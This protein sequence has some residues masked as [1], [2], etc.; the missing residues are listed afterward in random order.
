MP[1]V[2]VV[3]DTA[4]ERRRASGLL[5]RKPETGD[6]SA[7]TVLS[8]SNGE[9]ALEIVKKTRP[10]VIVT[11]LMMPGMNGLELVKQVR[12]HHPSIPVVLMTAHGSE[13]IASLALKFGA[14]G[15]VP[16]K[17]LARDLR[18]TIELILEMLKSDREQRDVL[19]H[20]EGRET[21][22]SLPPDP[23]LVD[24]AVNYFRQQLRLMAIFDYIDELRVTIALREALVNAFVHGCLEISS[25]LRTED[26]KAYRRAIEDRPREAPYKDRRVH[27]LS[28]EAQGEIRYV[29]R[30][31]GPGFPVAALPDPTDPAHLEKSTGRGIYLIR[32]FM[33][34]VAHNEAG[35]EITMTKRKKPDATPV[36]VPVADP[37]A[38]SVAEA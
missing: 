26:E 11:D 4:F 17:N 21:R 33:D 6:P 28:R 37:V 16:K 10:E 31:E 9:E 15:Y 19:R 1:T 25:E 14:A 30:D 7:W 36:A 13:D 3:D 24:P 23:T 35:N 12:E 34:D 38:V 20:L 22:F 5:E 32:T 18:P 27:V 29:V 8:A 2:L